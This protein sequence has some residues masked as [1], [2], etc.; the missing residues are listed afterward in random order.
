MEEGC[1]LDEEDD[2]NGSST[3]IFWNE[4]VEETDDDVSASDKLDK[5]SCTRASRKLNTWSS[6]D[7]VFLGVNPV[8]KRETELSP[9]LAVLIDELPEWSRK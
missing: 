8:D 9:L 7:V 6:S 4:E 1:A 2:G 5:Y 3:S